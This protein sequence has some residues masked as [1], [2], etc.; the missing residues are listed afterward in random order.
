MSALVSDASIAAMPAVYG[1][2]V[3]EAPSAAADATAL[4]LD[5]M[6]PTALTA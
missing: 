1:G 4:A 6:P 2:S 5:T 3:P